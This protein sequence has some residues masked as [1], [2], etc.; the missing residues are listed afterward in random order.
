MAEL[1]TKQNSANVSE[2]INVFA[3]SDQKRNWVAII[4]HID[5]KGG[6]I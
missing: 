6:G 2:F 5:T 3:D 4:N 1:K